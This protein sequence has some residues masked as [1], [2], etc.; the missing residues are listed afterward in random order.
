MKSKL[1]FF[2]ERLL[3]SYYYNQNYDE[4]TSKRYAYVAIR[5][6][7]GVI[8]FM[9]SLVL[10]VILRCVLE[11]NVSLKENRPIAYLLMVILIISYLYFSKKNIKPMFN[12]I[13]LKNEKP[14]KDYFFLILVV[15]LGLFGGGM[16][17]IARLLSIYL[18]G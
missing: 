14:P 7:I 2:Y 4:E 3:N 18:C 5:N 12:D 11:V 13:D 8:F 10:F 16:F 15:S 1:I 9:S 17:V 6:I